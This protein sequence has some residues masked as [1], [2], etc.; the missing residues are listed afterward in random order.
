MWRAIGKVT[1][2]P[3]LLQ[4]SDSIFTNL[5][6][7]AIVA[8]TARLEAAK[9]ELSEEKVVRLAADW[10][11]AEEKTAQQVVDQSLQAS[12][13]AKAALAQDLQF[14]KTSLT[15]TIEKLIS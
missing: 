7:S 15:A 1:N 13:E 6:I 11:L 14:A 9:K 8:L 4:A 5:M 3:L 2:P 12:E 10:S